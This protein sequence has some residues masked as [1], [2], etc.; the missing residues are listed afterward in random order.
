MKKAP[1]PKD[2]ARRK[3]ALDSLKVLD[4]SPEGCFDKVTKIASSICETKI[5]LVSL[6]DSERQ[7]FKSKHGLEVSETPRDISFCGH[8]ILGTSIFEVQDTQKDP[9]FADNP[10]C[11]GFPGIRF[12]AGAPLITSD[13]Y[14]VGTLC[15]IDQEP[16][17]LTPLQRDTLTV[18]AQQVISIL[19]MRL[20]RDSLQAHTQFYQSLIQ[21]IHDGLV[22]YGA[23][24]RIIEANQAA[25]GILGASREEL[26]GEAPNFLDTHAIREDGSEFPIR[27]LPGL[28]ALESGTFSQDV[29]LGFRQANG[30]LRW[31]KC[32]AS[33]FQT[34]EGRHVIVTFTDVTILVQTQ[35][36]KRLILK[37]VGVG[38]WRMNPETLE[39][40]WDA[41]L[42]PIY[43]LDPKDYAAAPPKWETLL[44]PETQ[45]AAYEVVTSAI[46]DKK[47]FEWT[48]EIVTKGGRRKFLSSRGKVIRDEKGKPIVVY[49][50]TIDRTVETELIRNLEL[51]RAKALHSA[52]LASLGEMSAGMAHEIN[53]PLTV[54]SGNLPF[55]KKFRENAQKFEEKFEV[56]EKAAERISKIVRG[57]QKFAR[58]TEGLEHRQESL[59]QIVQDALTIAEPKRKKNNVL[60]KVNVPKE[61]QLFCDS[62]EIEQVI[63]NL[64]NNGIDAVKPLQDR[65]IE[66]RASLDARGTLLQVIDSGSGIPPQI[67]DK[68]FQPFF[69]TKPVGEGTGLGLSIAKGIL[70]EHH[71]SISLNRTQP[72]TCFEIRFPTPP[73]LKTAS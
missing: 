28:V 53:N 16:K 29:T 42:Y 21:T 20:H 69:T 57:L 66:I 35:Q 64:V 48:F 24:G 70:D 59:L 25:Q 6:V 49:G 58:S 65:W 41:S 15:V 34:S 63:V 12:Y 62:V 51:E 22:V 19:E 23:D 10:L 32:N 8:T 1:I 60:V 73:A 46:R 43:D 11:V 4:T 52:K 38:V 45:K 26:M 67:E 50:V 27:E 3:K 9:D 36:R 39:V 55:L 54:I 33:P 61:I 71:A 7:W 13:G 37:S 5:A 47:E 68:I 2:E 56:I 72:H 17:K 18:L 44:S 31:L 14:R 30:E 40:H